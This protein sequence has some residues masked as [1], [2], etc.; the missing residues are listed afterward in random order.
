[1][2]HDMTEHCLHLGRPSMSQWV[3]AYELG[4]SINNVDWP[5]VVDNDGNTVQFQVIYC[6]LM[7]NFDYESVI[8]KHINVLYKLL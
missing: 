4:Y 8:V 3:T 1:M 5:Y 7:T 6:L 2:T